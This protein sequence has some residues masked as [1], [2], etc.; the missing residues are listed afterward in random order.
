MNIF[1][2]IGYPL[3]HSFSQKYFTEKFKREGII[4]TVYKNFEIEN[5]SLLP[6]I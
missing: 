1:G 5:I 6:Q 2:L 4:N 3:S